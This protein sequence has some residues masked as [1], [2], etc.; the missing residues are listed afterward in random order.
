MKEL[1]EETAMP[2]MPPCRLRV[3]PA[4]C[5]TFSVVLTSHIFTE[6]SGPPL[7]I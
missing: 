5:C 7:T 4:Q 3:W 1:S 6:A 2:L